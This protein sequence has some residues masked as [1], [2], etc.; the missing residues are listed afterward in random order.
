MNTP[1]TA[2]ILALLALGMIA[3][4]LVMLFFVPIPEANAST[5]Q[6][7]LGAALTWVGAV[8]NWFYGSSKSSQAKDETISSMAKVATGTGSGTPG[9]TTTTTTRETIGAMPPATG[10]PT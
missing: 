10:E 3:I 2:T 5:V 4:A 8:F 9:T 6:L 7:L 1:A